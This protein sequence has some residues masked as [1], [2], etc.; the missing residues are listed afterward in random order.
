MK[1]PDQIIIESSGVTG[2][3]VVKL[4]GAATGLLTRH[5]ESWVYNHHE[6]KS[7]TKAPTPALAI[8]RK[9]ARIYLSSLP[10]CP[11]N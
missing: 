9:L 4:D 3:Y 11:G 5:G 1:I 7:L 6:D 2:R 10:G 8:A